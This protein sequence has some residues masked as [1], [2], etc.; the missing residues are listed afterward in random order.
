MIPAEGGPAPSGGRLADNIAYF[1]RALRKAGVP[2]GPAQVV[3]AI[4][5]VELIGIGPREDF[6]WT[7][8]GIFIRRHEHS[9][10]FEQ[11]FDLFWR[12]RNLIEKMMAIMMP[13]NVPHVPHDKPKAASKRVADAIFDG[14]SQSQQPVKKP[15]IE[16]DAQFSASSDDVLRKKDFEQMSADEIAEARRQIARIRL[17]FP[18]VTTRRFRPVA[19]RQ[20]IDPRRTLK[21]SVRGGGGTITLM[22]RAPA[23]RYPPIVAICDISGSMSQYSRLFL[24]FLHALTDDYHRVHSFVFG[25]RLTN[26]TRQLRNKDADE[27]LENCSAAV[28]DWSGGTRI[29]ASLHAFNRNWS[30]RVLTQGA[31]VLL[32]TDGLEREDDGALGHEMDRLHRSCRRL[33]WLNPLLR[34]EGF[35][36]KAKGIRTMLPHVDAFCPIHNIESMQDLA[37]ALAGD[38]GRPRFDAGLWLDA[39]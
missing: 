11:A 16:I 31:I 18:P 8:H 17:A 36:A 25:T 21:A 14:I 37:E 33:I 20:K 19:H 32:I 23:K 10:L 39:A 30:R 13:S 22:H 6:Y 35:E 15:V 27:A 24:H 26:V 4:R 12:K 34:Y 9:E 3:D 7:L 28:Q 5:A 29:S 38:H 1:A 2:V